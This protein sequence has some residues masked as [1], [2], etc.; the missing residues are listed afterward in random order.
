MINCV[1]ALDFVRT[2]GAAATAAAVVDKKRRRDRGEDAR[3]FMSVTG[4]G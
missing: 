3:E 2:M 4:A 1:E